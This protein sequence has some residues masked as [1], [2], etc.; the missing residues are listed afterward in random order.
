MK[1]NDKS[2]TRASLLNEIEKREAV[3]GVIGLGYV[4]LPLAIHLINYTKNARGHRFESSIAHIAIQRFRI[5][6]R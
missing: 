3:I 1:G 6:S 2:M 5:S 4:G